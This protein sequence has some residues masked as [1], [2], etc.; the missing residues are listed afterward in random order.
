MGSPS[1]FRL[2]LKHEYLKILVMGYQILSKKT[3]IESQH[4]L[5][6]LTAKLG[7]LNKGQHT[8]LWE[9]FAHNKISRSQASDTQV[10]HSLALCF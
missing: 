8:A 10:L 7:T 1:G 2:L 5:D 6:T 9:T 4:Q 3:P